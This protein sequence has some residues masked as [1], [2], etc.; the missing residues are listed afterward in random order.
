MIKGDFTHCTSLQQFYDEI[1]TV[2]KEAHGE[3]YTSHHA[4]LID[5]MSQ[6]KTYKELGVNQ[7]ATA[8][9]VLLQVP[10][11]IELIDIVL[12]N[13]DEN[14]HLFEQF[15]QDNDVVMSV[16]QIGSTDPKLKIT[17]C[18]LLFVDSLHDS[19][20]VRQELLLH[21]P[22]TNKFIVIHDTGDRPMNHAVALEALSP[23]GWK[24]IGWD[25]CGKGHSIFGKV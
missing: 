20:H 10:K 3:L 21:G 25:L 24:A 6:C 19:H 8:A 22:K 1:V 7:G 5:L 15:A 9:A 2:Q 11:S 4:D 14:R 16:N 13:F 23:L 18:D 12:T 17:E